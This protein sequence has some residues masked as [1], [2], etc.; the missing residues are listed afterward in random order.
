VAGGCGAAALAPAAMADGGGL[1]GESRKCDSGYGFDRGLHG[2]DAGSTRNESRGSGWRDGA[3]ER[4]T[5]AA[6]GRGAPA[7]HCARG[8]AGK[9]RE[10]GPATM[11]TSTRSFCSGRGRRS[12]SEAARWRQAQAWR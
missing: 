10:K 2:K 7:R 3:G 5:V 11:S 6:H 9:Q 8:K 12:G 4:R 1:A